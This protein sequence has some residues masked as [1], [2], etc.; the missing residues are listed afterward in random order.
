[1][2][3]LT[4][5]ISDEDLK[6]KFMNCSVPSVGEEKAGKIYELIMDLENVSD[7]RSLTALSVRAGGQA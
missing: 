4:D 5:P 3:H 7:V 6:I 2:G 1:M